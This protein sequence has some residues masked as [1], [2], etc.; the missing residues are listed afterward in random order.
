MRKSKIFLALP[1]CLMFIAGP[2]LAQEASSKIVGKVTEK[3]GGPLPGV[4]IEATNPKQLGKTATVSDTNGVYRL[5]ALTPGVFR[6]VFTLK[7]F[8]TLVREDVVLELGQTLDLN[9]SLDMGVIEEQITVTG[10]SPIVDVKSTVKG[11]VMT[12][13]VFATLPKSR[14]FDGLIST[15]PG[16]QYEGITGGLSVDGASGAENVWHIDG[17]DI[18][19]IAV[20]TRAEDAVY[21]F[22]EEIKVTASGYPAEFGGSM[23]GVVNV[24]TR[25]GGNAFHGDIVGYYNDNSR[26]MQGHSR[27]YL[28]L[29][30]TNDSI[31]EYVNDDNLY[32]NGGK[33][34]DRWSRFEGVFSL[35]GYI[36]KDRI[37]FFGS[38]NPVYS[39]TKASRYFLSDPEPRP[40]YAY[41]NKNWDYNY[42]FKLTVQPFSS[43]RMSASV[44]NNFTKWRGSIPNITGVDDK[45]FLWDK[46]GFDYPNISG[47]FHADYTGGNDL[48]ISFRAG[49]F[50]TDN[51]VNQQLFMP[52]TAWNFSYANDIYPEIPASL[53]RYAGWTNWSGDWMQTLKNVHSRATA[54][55]DF[56]YY[57]NLAGQHAWKAGVLFE[58]Q[59][60][61]VDSAAQHPIVFL[62]WGQSYEGPTGIVQGK[63]GYYE[64]ISGF[65]SKYGSLW[66]IHRDRW[67][68]YL[69]DSWTI[70]NRLTLNL[71]IRTESEYIPSFSNAPQ[72]KDVVPVDFKFKD[73]FAPRIGAV[74]D[75]FGDSSLKVFGS[76]GIYYDVMKLYVAEGSFG[77]FQWVS[78]Y[79][80]LDNY[81]WTQIAAS[82]DVNDKA[83]Q[84][85]GNTY[86]FSRDWRTNSFDTTDPT[87]K[88]TSQREFTFGVEKK[89]NDDLSVS[90]RLVQKHLIWTIEDVGTLDAYGNE[91]YYLTNPGRGFARP[92]TQGGKMDPNVWTTPRARRE[93]WGLNLSIEK[94]FSNNWQAG[95]NYTWSRASGNYSGLASSDEGGR[96]SPN[97]ERDFDG[98][99]LEYDLKGNE[100]S[101]PLA[102]DRTHYLK[103]YGSY[104]FPFGLTVGV[105]AYGRSGFPLTTIL[106]FRDMGYYPNNRFDTG[107]RLPFT[108]WSDLYL[109]YNL[110]LGTRYN[111]QINLTLFNFT[112]TSKAQSKFLWL[113]RNSIWAD[114][115]E[116]ITKTYDYKAQL[117]DANPDPRFNK[118]S[119]YFGP[120]SARL[121]VRF[122]F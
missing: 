104:V 83:S 120:W 25:S 67:A 18:S 51:G 52:G 39:S 75:V 24:I 31:A 109:E 29:N 66:N 121:G 118:F 13:E 12:R 19:D 108:F 87:M 1:V 91:Y 96:V 55:L 65:T 54:A 107:E 57:M 79:Y 115:A 36:I 89:L 82:G 111:A 110:K 20:G 2:L 106:N 94:R 43:L 80:A 59:G 4:T 58:R 3:E 78:D 6:L 72:Y 22:V 53:L 28:R 33:D 64:I 73:K 11:Q 44:V 17:T 7:G 9:V 113:N 10:Q 15:I 84:Q 103:A 102:S 97:Q 41:Y 8:Q 30:P 74:Y 114:D 117:A 76:F 56:T 70:K 122:S 93:Y 112:N 26:L 60:E 61:T 21:E 32:F 95:F 68:L 98:W 81:D 86:V 37:W 23:G 100:L 48:L 46:P 85:N 40:Q 38:L 34:R 92:T 14:N 105:V 63:Y 119:S 71:G 49:Y 116:I 35:G 99:F 77:G 42:Q 62:N 50:R 69:Q 88:P 27:D 101:G 16:V 47:S 45:S 5:L 90:A